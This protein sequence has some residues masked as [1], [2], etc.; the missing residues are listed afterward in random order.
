MD[1]TSEAS[2]PS[3]VAKRAI[4]SCVTDNFIGLGAAF[5]QS[6]VAARSIPRR[7]DVLFLTHPVHAPLSAEHRLMLQRIYPPLRFCP[8]DAA[9]LH[10]DL[11]RRWK[12]GQVVKQA[13]DAALPHKRS[14]YLKLCLFRLGVYRSVLWMDSDMIVLRGIGS[15]F[16]L[17]VNL[18]VVP[19]GASNHEHGLDYGPSRHG[20]NSGFMF[21]RRPYLT[22]E[23]LE[24]AIALLEER[25]H[26][27]MQDQSL[28]NHL[29]REEPILYLPHAYNWKVPDEPTAEFCED[30]LRTARVLHFAGRSKW[31]LALGGPG[32]ALTRC[33][34][35]F[36]AAS[37]AP[38]TLS[39]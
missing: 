22:P 2:G 9:F 31:S 16:D 19:A 25:E 8:V 11:T 18:A 4:V 13:V 37:G 7:T 23:W 15:V 5:L 21:I 33:F 14:V 30:A 12:G 17:P 39:G 20:F 32:N 38:L 6:L 29:W 3:P 1:E 10:E 35:S 36:H 34:H 28:L 26:T 24:R 27:M